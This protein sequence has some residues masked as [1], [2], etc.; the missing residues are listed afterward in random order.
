MAGRTNWREIRAKTIDTP[1]REAAVAREGRLLELRERL[2]E[3]R[4]HAGLS[5]TDL[6]ERIGMTQ[7]GVSRIE[8]G[9]DPKLSTLEH[10]VAA[11]GARLEIRA[12]FDDD[13][14]V[15][16]AGDGQDGEAP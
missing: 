9:A 7:A 12:V 13:A 4:Q 2:H 10:Y 8:R 1:E 15:V 6:A 14:V 3:A 5:Q 16:L 11:L